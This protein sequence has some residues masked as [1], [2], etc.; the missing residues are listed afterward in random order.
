MLAIIQKKLAEAAPWMYYENWIQCSCSALL[1]VFLSGHSQYYSEKS[2]CGPKSIF[3]ID[4]HC[5]RDVCKTVDRTP[6]AVNMV[7]YYS[8]HCIFLIHGRLFNLFKNFSK[9]QKCH[10]CSE[11]CHRCVRATWLGQRHDGINTTARIQWAAYPRSK[12]GS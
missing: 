11:W 1:P 8:W 2:P 3:P 5:K 4:H 10:F 12:P 6:P 9:A 7:S